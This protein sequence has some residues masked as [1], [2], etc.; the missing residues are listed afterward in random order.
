MTEKSIF[1]HITAHKAYN[2]ARYH[3]K[4]LK[5]CLNETFKNEINKNVNTL[6]MN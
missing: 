2:W 5:Q 6:F 4:F 1:L 3:R